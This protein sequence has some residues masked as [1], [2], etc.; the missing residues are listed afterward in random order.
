MRSPVLLAGALA[1]AL[2]SPVAAQFKATG[3]N[4]VPNADS[5]WK[6][7]WTGYLTETSNN[8]VPVP[9][10]TVPAVGG[11]W[12]PNSGDAAWISAWSVDASNGSNP[13]DNA[14]RFVYVFSQTW[15]AA[16]SGTGS[17]SF[18]LGWDNLLRSISLNDVA[19]DLSTALQ[20][21][22]VA[23]ISKFGFCRAS[24]GMFSS[25]YPFCS[26]L[27]RIDGIKAGVS[28]KL[29]FTIQ[30]DGQ[31]DGMILNPDAGG[32]LTEIVPE[33]ATMTLL[34]TGLI[35]MAGSSIRRRRNSPK[36]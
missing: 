23:D 4:G 18:F 36:A 1:L 11:V 28:N 10:Y 22:P 30:G 3:L 34:A 27:F 32:E 33:P 31:T 21:I 24:D 15:T 35:G 6:V 2:A 29:S 13:G 19:V 20:P 8:S 25:G 16:G 14:A 5:Y 7:S 26:A 9:A 17:L 12:Q